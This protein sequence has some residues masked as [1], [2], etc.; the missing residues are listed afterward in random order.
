MNARTRDYAIINTRGQ[1]SIF[2]RRAGNK[3][4]LKLHCI[5]FFL[6]LILNVDQKVGLKHV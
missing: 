3:Y 4:A 5:H 6:F 2:L 1:K